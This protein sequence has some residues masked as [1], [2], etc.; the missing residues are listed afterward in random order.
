MLGQSDMTDKTLSSSLSQMD[1]SLSSCLSTQP[2][3]KVDPTPAMRTP[4][5]GEE[6]KESKYCLTSKN[7][8]EIEETSNESSRSQLYYDTN[9]NSIIST[10]FQELKSEYWTGSSSERIKFF[11]TDQLYCNIKD[12]FYSKIIGRYADTDKTEWTSFIRTF[13][14]LYGPHVKNELNKSGK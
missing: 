1:K 9:A 8:S 11:E 14:N 13:D 10:T 5:S 6:M 7:L 3:T 2:K 4:N 12:T